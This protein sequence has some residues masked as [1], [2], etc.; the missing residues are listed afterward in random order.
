MLVHN[1]LHRIPRRL[2]AGTTCGGGWGI[3]AHGR[4]G[5][6]LRGRIISAR[7]LLVRRRGSRAIGCCVWSVMRPAAGHMLYRV[8]PRV[9]QSDALVVA[10]V[11]WVMGWRREDWGCCLIG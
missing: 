5:L 4:R 6:V 9:F 1:R 11:C 10:V 8:L 7:M 2:V 3:L